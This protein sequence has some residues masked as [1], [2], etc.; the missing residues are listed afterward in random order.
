MVSS[1]KTKGHALLYD[2]DGKSSCARGVVQTI[3]VGFCTKRLAIVIFNI[4]EA[5]SLAAVHK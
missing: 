5:Y 1:Q 4:K 3:P 2:W